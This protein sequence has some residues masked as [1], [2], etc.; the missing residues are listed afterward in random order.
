MAVSMLT[1]ERGVVRA[2]VKG[3]RGK[4]R[5]AA[6]LQTLNELEVTWFQKEGAELAR[7]DA[8]EVLESSFSLAT[9]PETAMLLPY[10]AESVLAFVPELEPGGD[11]YR[12]TAHVLHSLRAGAQP[13][14]CLRYFE[15]WMLRLAGVFPAR[16]VCA[17]CGEPFPESGPVSLEPEIPGF[18]HRACAGQAATPV[19][20]RA[21][22]A[23]EELRKKSLTAL[24]SAPSQALGSAFLVEVGE[25]TRDMR[26]RF[27]NHEL[28][29]YR[30]L[31]CLEGEGDR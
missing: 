24:S 4:S 12:L 25:L 18:V 26:R 15:T 30:F 28:K 3:A 23:L 1:R 27:L 2:A 10:I 11:V 31:Q 9:R 13:D 29:S 14:L 17:A 22:R 20:S 8:L 19:S 21:W 5:R 6:A 7:L 16:A